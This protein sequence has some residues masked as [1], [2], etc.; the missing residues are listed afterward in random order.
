MKSIIAF[1]ILLSVTFISTAQTV[2][3]P[4][5]KIDLSSVGKIFLHQEDTVGV[6]VN[7]TGNR[8]KIRT[9]VRNG[10]LVIS[11]K[12]DAEYNITMKNIEG[13]SVSGSGE[14][15]GE[16]PLNADELRLD[17]SGSGKMTLQLAVKKLNIDIS[18]VGKE[19]LS[20]T[21]GEAAI[22]ISGSGKV[23]AFELKVPS[24]T[25]NISGVGKCNIDVTDNLKTDISGMGSINYKT[26]PKNMEQNISG[27]GKINDGPRHIGANDGE[28]HSSG[29]DTTR[30]K[31][32]QSEVLFISNDSSKTK[33]KH[34][35]E[36]SKPIW[37][38]LELGFNNYV[39]ASG[40][41]GLT[42]KYDFLDLNTGKS[43]IVSLNLL[44]KDIQFSKSSFW[45]FT[46]L[47][48]TWNNYRFDK[49]LILNPDS[50]AGSMHDTTSTHS[51]Q[52]SKL[53]ATYL[54]APLMFEVFTSHKR[55]DAFHIGAGAMLGYRIGSHTKVKF[56]ENGNT[57]KPKTYDDFNLNPFRY[58]LR[59]A[60]GYRK[61][62]VFTDFYVSTLFKNNQHPY[63]YP[64]DFG[65]TLVGF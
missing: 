61:F 40:S 17:V 25:A 58:G 64:M 55:K 60:A 38:G 52:K 8:E 14:I 6:V 30:F 45:F 21:A 28:V 26:A 42:D 10:T 20:G 1:L 12:V 59:V 18:G 54:T 41:T 24:V 48:L 39:N 22:D 23:D 16:T 13:I 5:T 31:L 63:V 53:T 49:N 37:S 9:E 36:S 62:N 11:S 34:K 32:G 43:V 65:I 46:G 19:I 3:E 2:T 56:E 27:V 33:H 35:K 51:Y 57:S 7:T 4:F 29:K 50:L 47:G 44:Q 15:I